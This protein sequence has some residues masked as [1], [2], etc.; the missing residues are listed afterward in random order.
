MTSRQ[1]CR[2]EDVATMIQAMKG[3][4]GDRKG[5]LYLCGGCRAIGHLWFDELS[6]RAV[7][8]AERFADG[9]ATPEELHMAN[10]SAEGT[11][12][13]Y[14]FEPGVWRRWHPDGTVPQ[15]VRRLVEMGALT[16]AQLSEDKPEVDPAV[17]NR[18]L[19]A[20][21]LA[22]EAA[23]RSPFDYDWWH[24]Y[25]PRVPWP[26]T[27]MMRCVFGD[28]FLPYVFFSPTWLTPEVVDLAR[29]IYDDR[30]FDRMPLLGKALDEAGCLNRD[31]IEHCRS[32]HPHVRGCWVVDLALGLC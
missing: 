11:A 2:C 9:L 21:S 23:S 25:I 16:T 8:V 28:P 14:D 3:V 24:C 19:A 17:R 6:L 29:M 30:A 22:E 18:L 26:G 27:W 20:A 12:F 10:Y 4:A 1:W 31:M 32:T 5:R 15:S 13:G 7:E